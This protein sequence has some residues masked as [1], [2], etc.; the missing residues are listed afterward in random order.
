MKKKPVIKLI[1]HGRDD[2]M[3]GMLRAYKVAE[4]R[5]PS[6]KGCDK[7]LGLRFS[8]DFYS[9]KWNRASISVWVSK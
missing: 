7:L 5:Y 4:E 9:I 6:G 8:E 2:E 3:F 1:L